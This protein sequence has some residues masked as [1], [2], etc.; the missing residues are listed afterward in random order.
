MMAKPLN[1]SAVFKK[2]QEKVAERARRRGEMLRDLRAFAQAAIR[3]N[4]AEAQAL[5]RSRAKD[6]LVTD[7][8]K[9]YMPIGQ[10]FLQLL[11]KHPAPGVR[12]SCSACAR[13]GQVIC[14]DCG[15]A[16]MRHCPTC[17]SVI[18]ADAFCGTCRGKYIFACTT[19]SETGFLPCAKCATSK[20]SSLRVGGAERKELNELY[21]YCDYLLNGGFDLRLGSVD[22]EPPPELQ[23]PTSGKPPPAG[24][25]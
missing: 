21:W 7:L 15:G 18:L 3:K 25:P 20:T 16:G 11:A 12:A 14:K 4:F 22:N 8:L 1:N 19:C 6:P 13:T 23:A 24:T 2:V 5:Q 9:A 10:A 17:M